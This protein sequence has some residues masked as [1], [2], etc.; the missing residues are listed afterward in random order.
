M[1]NLYYRCH[2]IHEDIPSLCYTII[3][4]RP[5]RS[6]LCRSSSLM[7]AMHWV[8]RQVASQAAPK[9]V[10]RNPTWQKPTYDR[11]SQPTML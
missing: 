2:V 4:R 9:W 5:E 6:E 1:L 11:A 10:E 8:D 7:D 3:G